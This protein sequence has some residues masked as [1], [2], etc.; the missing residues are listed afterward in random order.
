MLRVNF[1]LE[2]MLTRRGKIKSLSEYEQVR[3]LLSVCYGTSYLYLVLE[4]VQVL[5]NATDKGSGHLS[6]SEQGAYTV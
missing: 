6:D 5:R 1:K 3:N 4:D 2:I